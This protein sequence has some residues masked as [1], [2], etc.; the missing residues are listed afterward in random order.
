MPFLPP[1]AVIGRDSSF[2]MPY[3]IDDLVTKNNLPNLTLS[4]KK[5]PVT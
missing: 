3:K 1:Q 2:T 5:Q 4:N